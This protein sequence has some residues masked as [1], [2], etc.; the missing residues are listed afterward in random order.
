MKLLIALATITLLLATSLAAQQGGTTSQTADKDL[1]NR[2]REYADALTKRDSATLDK[3][4]APEYTFI[5]PRGEVVTKEQRMANL[6]SGATEFKAINPQ[7]EKLQLHGDIAIDIGRVNL[8]GTRYSGKESSG[9]YRYMNVWVKK[10]GQ[11]QMLANQITLI[12]K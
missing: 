1:Q 7:Q 2:F 8:E 11:W 3:I 12:A 4:W 10:Q 6:K 9:E 5:N